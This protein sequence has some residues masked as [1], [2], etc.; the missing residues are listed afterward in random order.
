MVVVPLKVIVPVPALKVPLF[1][2][3]PLILKPMALPEESVPFMYRLL[4]VAVAETVTVWPLEI[5]IEW[6]LL[7]GVRDAGFHVMLSDELSHVEG[8]FQLPVVTA[9]RK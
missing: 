1:F 9:E 8:E 5:V 6:A 7:S 4:A 3:M 2:Q